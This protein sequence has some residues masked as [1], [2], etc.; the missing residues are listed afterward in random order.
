MSFGL[1]EGNK[2]SQTVEMNP[3]SNPF[4]FWWG[5]GGFSALACPERPES[6][7]SR[8][9]L[10][11]ICVN[12]S[13][14]AFKNTV[15]VPR[16]LGLQTLTAE[17]VPV[18]ITCRVTL[19]GGVLLFVSLF[20]AWLPDFWKEPLATLGNH[21]ILPFHSNLWLKRQ[22]PSCSFRT[23]KRNACNHNLYRR[24]LNRLR[25]SHDEWSVTYI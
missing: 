20:L 22:K 18:L 25:L 5:G 24:A 2:N 6:I 8:A 11:S 4:V 13:H 10:N 14:I 1:D 12:I 9:C 15:V 21:R 3:K 16:G 17:D 19:S 23:E 7:R